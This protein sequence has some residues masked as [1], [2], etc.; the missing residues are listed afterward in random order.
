MKGDLG[1]L[2][3]TELEVLNLY[4][5]GLKTGEIARRRFVSVKTVDSHHQNILAKTGCSTM[6]QV[7][8]WA[9]DKGLIYERATGK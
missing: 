2:T 8:I 4:G 1:P 3:K 5:Q 9:V 6:Y 7:M